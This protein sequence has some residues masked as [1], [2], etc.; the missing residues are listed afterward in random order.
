M[1][2]P[3]RQLLELRPQLTD[4]IIVDYITLAHLSPDPGRV[5][6]SDLRA[7]WNCSQPQVS[8]RINAVAAAGLVDITPGCG[9]YQ[10][11]AI[12][13]LEVVK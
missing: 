3:I 4:Q 12:R 13:R 11:H 2:I 1:N 7:R 9:A 5:A 6:L 10:V 8:R